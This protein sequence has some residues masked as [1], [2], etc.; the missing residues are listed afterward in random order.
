M[1]NII[2]TIA[3][4]IIGTSAF[5]QNNIT[6]AKISFGLKNLGIK[7]GGVIGGVQGNIAFD[8]AKLA[9]SKI[10]ATADV[11]AINTDND[12]RD[13]HLKRDDYFDVQKYPKMSLSSVSFKKNSGNNFTGVFN[14]TVKGITKTV[15]VP[16][17]YTTVATGNLF[18]GSFK[19]NRKDF[20]IGGN[21]M[22]MSDDVTINFEAE[23]AK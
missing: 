4:L 9:T 8:P 22:T 14:L 3:F 23:A 10:E 18:N 6:K 15:E 19:I 17:T 21:S 20:K 12:M 13:E 16:F 2:V 5:A 7:T 1:K 11:N